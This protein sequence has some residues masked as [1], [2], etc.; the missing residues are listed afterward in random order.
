MDYEL[1][2]YEEQPVTTGSLRTDIQW[3]KQALLEMKRDYIS[4]VEFA[5]VKLLVYGLVTIIMS[6]VILTILVVVLGL[7]TRL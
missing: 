1:E 4:R 2:G 7:R 3:I 6:A 5:P